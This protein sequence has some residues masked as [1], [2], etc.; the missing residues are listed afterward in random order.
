MG[1]MGLSQAW[2][3]ALLSGSLGVLAV[4]LWA[5]CDF[6]YPHGRREIAFAVRRDRYRLVLAGYVWIAIVAYGLAGCACYLIGHQLL[7]FWW[8]TPDEDRIKE[9][10]RLLTQVQQ[11]NWR[12]E[13]AGVFEA[14]ERAAG[15][16][17]RPLAATCAA[18]AAAGLVTL[19]LPAFPY[20]KR[21]IAQLRQA[22]HAIALYP[23]ARDSL[24]AILGRSPFSA[25]EHAGKGLADALARYGV[26]ADRAALI[27]PSVRQSLEELWFIAKRLQDKFPDLPERSVSAFKEARGSRL[28]ELEWRVERL[29]RRTATALRYGRDIKAQT[30]SSAGGV[31]IPTSATAESEELARQS[32][33]A[34]GDRVSVAI[35]TF[36][37]EESED[38]LKEARKLVAEFALSNTDD[39]ASRERL[40][41]LFGYGCSLPNRLPLAAPALLIAILP[42]ELAMFLAPNLFGKGAGLPLRVALAFALARGVCQIAAVAW[43]IF[44]KATSSFARPSAYSLPWASYAVFGAASFVTSFI[45]FVLLWRVIQPGASAGLTAFFAGANA[46]FFVTLTVV[47][48]V[49]IDRRLMSTS[50]VYDNGRG[51]DAAILGMGLAAVTLAF[52]VLVWWVVGIR[53]GQTLAQF[54][55]LRAFF[56]VMLGLEAALIGYILPAAAAEYLEAKAVRTRSDMKGNVSPIGPARRTNPT[57][58]LHRPASSAVQSSSA[59]IPPT[60]A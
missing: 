8:P 19:A 6:H 40:L 16:V 36:V 24:V 25:P 56:T 43:S 23:F 5:A 9:G 12:Q 3:P 42:I 2:W 4:A 54:L 38:L 47:L 7:S 29:L 35:S 13:F 32:H 59:S 45:V 15:L 55:T 33:K 46:M 11:E 28:Q 57:G 60:R 30:E 27:A 49:R 10:L 18:V 31:A 21:I 26:T 50:F 22:A 39:P 34:V 58:I 41:R 52:F 44:P 17:K 51:R 48:S 37:T 20:T 53:Q 14:R 1:W